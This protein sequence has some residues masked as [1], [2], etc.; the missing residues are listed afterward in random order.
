[1]REKIR[2]IAQ[3]F[4][5]KYNEISAYLTAVICITVFV[6]YSDFRK[7]IWEIGSALAHEEKLITISLLGI[8]ALAGC[9]LSIVHVFLKRTKSPI[10]KI[11]IGVFC[12]AA[13]ALAAIFAGIEMIPAQFSFMIVFPIMN[14]LMGIFLIY[15]I[16]LQNFEI[17]DENASCGE[18]LIGM[19]FIIFVI[20]VLLFGFKVSWS[21]TFSMSLFCSSVFSFLY[22]WIKY[23]VQMKKDR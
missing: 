21:M 9:G 13:N 22:S 6:L 18:T 7:T 10:E 5:P 4:K 16:A 1:M 20:F 14:I 23:Q 8:M 19:L 2:E 17:S 11:L 15:Q 3:F 12:L